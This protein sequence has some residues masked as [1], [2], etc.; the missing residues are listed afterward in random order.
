MS[1]DYIRWLIFD[2]C[3]GLL[4]MD[5][6]QLAKVMG[7]SRPTL[8]TYKKKPEL[9]TAKIA[10]RLCDHIEFIKSNLLVTE[11]AKLNKLFNKENK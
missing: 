11:T 3:I 4:N 9:V 10:D 8:S 5:N 2:Q 7:V 6:T 1:T